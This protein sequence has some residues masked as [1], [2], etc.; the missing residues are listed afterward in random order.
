MIFDHNS[1]LSASLTAR[2]DL[3]KGIFAK[4]SS[5]CIRL[6]FKDDLICQLVFFDV[7]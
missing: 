7:V 2:N 3:P 1:P 6:A 5:V 4:A